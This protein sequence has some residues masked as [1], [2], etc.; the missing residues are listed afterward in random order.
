GGTT[1]VLYQQFAMTIA[2]S[3]AISS[4]VAL[5]LTPALAAIL[6]KPRKREPPFLF[7]WFNRVMDGLI[8][9][10]AVGVRLA[11]KGA[12]ISLVALGVMLWGTVKLFDV[13]PGS[14]VPPEDQGY[15]FAAVML[16][17][18]AS[19]DRT[20][21]LTQKVAEIF[22]EQPAVKDYSAMAGYSFLD[23]QFKNNAGTVFVSFKDFS[24]RQGEGMSAEDVFAA[25]RPRLAALRE[26]IALAINPPPIPGLGS[27]GGFGF[28]L[29][30]RG[31]GPRVSPGGRGGGAPGGG[32]CSGC[33]PG[34]GG[35]WGASPR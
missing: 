17:D 10:Y 19:L 22:A 16:P 33:R 34:A 6:L 2:V 13:V 12:P 32:S 11:I 3:V 26:G 31:P 23:G 29:Q 28:W 4:F 24:D 7:R 20:Q 18:G 27:Q 9:V 8:A 30:N 25:V 5:T 14:F 15:C 35:G 1:G 21:A